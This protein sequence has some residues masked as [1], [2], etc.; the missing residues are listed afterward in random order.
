MANEQKLVAKLTATP[1]PTDFRWSELESLLGKL[2]FEQ[3]TGSGSRRKFFHSETKCLISLH[4]PH[5]KPI[6][7]PYM[8]KDIVSKLREHGFLS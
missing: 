3:R 1:T 6:L 8:I 5:P 2:G 7:K 4:E